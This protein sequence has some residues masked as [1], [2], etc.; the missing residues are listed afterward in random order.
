MTIRA[1]ESSEPV[2]YFQKISIMII[3]TTYFYAP[4]ESFSKGKIFMSDDEAHHLSVVLRAKDGDEFFVTNGIGELFKCR[5]VKSH[6]KGVVAEVV[7]QLES[8]PKPTV[9]LCLA[10]G[11]IKPKLME[12]ALDWTVQLGIS[13]FS[14]LETSYTMRELRQDSERFAR[15]EKV[16]LRAMKQSRRTWLPLVHPAMPIEQFLQ[17]F[18][19]NFDGLLYADPDGVPTPPKRMIQSDL[20]VLV[21]VGPEGG[22][23]TAEKAELSE[24]GAV[25]ISLGP[26]RLRT[27]T[28]AVAIAAKILLWS[29]NM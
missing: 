2:E 21:I 27:E 15:L 4:P 12:L 1:L 16:A 20:K 28:A 23:S 24:Y 26:A 18:A 14:P 11:I 19:K 25:P 3:K 5:L 9:E 29:G 17:K 10:M 22:L 13:E 7:E 6:K 8:I